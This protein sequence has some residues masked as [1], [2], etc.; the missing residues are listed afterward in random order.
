M[1]LR[2]LLAE[3]RF[4]LGEL[5]FLLVTAALRLNIGLPWG[6]FRIIRLRPEVT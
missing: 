3:L 5:R 4:L 2:F 6:H 1:E